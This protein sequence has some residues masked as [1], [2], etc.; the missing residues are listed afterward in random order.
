LRDIYIP[1]YEIKLYLRERLGMDEMKLNL[2]SKF[3]RKMVSKLMSRYLS[4]QIG[5][6][7]TLDLNALNVR[8]DDGDTV[9]KTDLELRMDKHEFRRLMKKV[10]IDEF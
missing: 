8:F 2:G 9:I 1:L 6:K 5:S 3:M 4:K 7:V 10:D